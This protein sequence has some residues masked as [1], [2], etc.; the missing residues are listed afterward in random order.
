MKK[1]IYL[2]FL[3]F[4]LFFSK[5][6]AL[7]VEDISIDNSSYST[8][9]IENPLWVAYKN[10]GASNTNII[11]PE[12]IPEQKETIL[13]RYNWS[14]G[15]KASGIPTSYDLRNVDGNNYVTPNKNQ[16]ELGL[17]WAF[18]TISSMESYL[19]KHN[20]SNLTNNK[21]TFNERQL[22]YASVYGG[23]QITSLGTQDFRPFSDITWNPYA[24]TSLENGEVTYRNLG[25]GGSFQ[26][27]GYSL[28]RGFSPVRQETSDMWSGY[29]TT[30][31]TGNEISI[32]SRDVFDVDDIEYSVTGFTD[33]VVYYPGY[34]S[35]SAL[36]SMRNMVKQQV[37]DHGAVYVSTVAPDSSVVNSCAY[38]TGSTYVINWRGEVVGNQYVSHCGDTDVFSYLHAMSIIGWDDDYSISYCVKND[39]STTAPLNGTGC[40]SGYF[41][42]DVNGAWILK[43]SWG[44]T[45][46]YVYLAYDSMAVQFSGITGMKQ[47][48]WDQNY[49]E[50]ATMST[51]SIS[52][53][54]Y[55]RAFKKDISGNEVLERVN[56][57]H[58]ATSTSTFNV[59]VDPTGTGTFQ[60]FGSVVATQ[61]G[62]VSVERAANTS[63][64]LSSDRFVIKVTGRDGLVDRVYAF[65]SYQDNVTNKHLDFTMIPGGEVVKNNETYIRS[66]VYI[67]SRNIPCGS[68]LKFSFG[69]ANSNQNISE[70]FF[71][72]GY[73]VLFNGAGY[74][75]VLYK[76]NNVPYGKYQFKVTDIASGELFLVPLEIK[77]T[78]T[79]DVDS[80]QIVVGQQYLLNYNVVN[81][82]S[83]QFNYSYDSNNE[84]VA[85]LGESP[86]TTSGSSIQVSG[87]GEGSTVV[88]VNIIVNGSTFVYPMN[89]TVSRGFGFNVYTESGDYVY[90]PPK[91]DRTAFEENVIC[92]SSCTYVYDNT[93]NYLGTG[94][95]FV[96]KKN[97]NVY[98]T[99]TIV[100]LGDVTGDGQIKSND[101]LYVERKLATLI[102]LNSAQIKAADTKK[103]GSIKSNDALYIKRYLANIISE[104]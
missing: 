33:F 89:V 68:G 3:I 61:P 32:S 57:I 47:K 58:T 97:G 73:N 100:V 82:S 66:L 7:E 51:Q 11:I 18:S 21:V 77:P 23:V 48:D 62:M 94:T 12:Y 6:N 104:F 85:I 99:Y 69:T 53:D 31:N 54:G 87:I 19:L 36:L 35:D 29:W 75:E 93:G 28:A 30:T 13:E 5:A 55:Y 27:A 103:D 72:S 20:M 59:W 9:L 10:S 86:S 46:P 101:A 91:L 38:Y 4:L 14:Y 90:I 67:S 2:F 25:S 60:K 22:D 80:V 37:M 15:A 52:G 34:H 88:N 78:L 16:A 41:K 102:T 65:T 71:L 96:V 17:C 95:S 45:L 70:W 43:N 74:V 26:T 8:N 44:S 42:V 63:I 83:M 50:I 98:K 1:Y 39:Y 24:F 76:K 64:V 79:Y 81:N 84:N 49:E 40:N 92:D 56:I